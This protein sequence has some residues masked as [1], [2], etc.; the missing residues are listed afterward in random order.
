MIV[1]NDCH[2]KKS[3][4]L[5]TKLAV[6]DERHESKSIISIKLIDINDCNE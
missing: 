1:V 4:L 3:R 5:P 2:E 6:V